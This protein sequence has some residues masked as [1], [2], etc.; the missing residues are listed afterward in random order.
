VLE[1]ARLQIASGLLS[2]RH[3]GAHLARV[4]G[5]SQRIEEVEIAEISGTSRTPA[6]EAVLQLIAAGL[7]HKTPRLDWTFVRR[8]T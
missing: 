4:S 2:I 3:R 1:P 7:L 5:A 6:R 8:S